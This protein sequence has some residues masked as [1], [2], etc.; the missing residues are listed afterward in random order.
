MC[1]LAGALERRRSLLWLAGS[2]Q[3]TE[4]SSHQW[5][6]WESDSGGAA[7]GA[8]WPPAGKKESCGAWRASWRPATESA[9]DPGYDSGLGY[10]R[11]GS[12]IKDHEEVALRGNGRARPPGWCM[13]G[14]QPLTATLIHHGAG[15]V[16][17]RVATER[18]FTLV[19]SGW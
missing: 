13:E 1:V 6:T 2:W 4:S 3:Y 7:G 16:D 9:E 5:G 12:G 17:L 11:A 19:E 14:G 18:R 8:C 15:S 10:E